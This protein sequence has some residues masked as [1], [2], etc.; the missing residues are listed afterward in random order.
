MPAFLAVPPV[1][2]EA[3]PPVKLNG[4]PLDRSTGTATAVPLLLQLTVFVPAAP[5]PGD[6]QG[7]AVKLGA[8]IRSLPECRRRT[9]VRQLLPG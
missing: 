2:V 5:L 6:M 3:P 9:S 7:T 8:A 4:G 1:I